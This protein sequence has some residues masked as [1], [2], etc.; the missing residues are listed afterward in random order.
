[1]R[2]SNAIM[3]IAAAMFIS[4]SIGAAPASAGNDKFLGVW[5][6]TVQPMGAPFTVPN[7]AANTAD[8]RIVNSDPTFGAGHGLW[9]KIG[10]RKYAVSLTHIIDAS[11][12][13]F[14]APPGQP[15]VRVTVEGVT[16]VKKDGQ[17]ASGTFVTTFSDL[18][19]APIGSFE[20]DVSFSRYKIA[21]D[22]LTLSEYFTAAR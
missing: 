4:F 2:I 13:P 10:N 3:A 12:S 22:L 6:V 16:K 19:G 7:I 20:G 18:T 1:M 5:E 14:P 11:L 9:E 17:T 15:F 21:P 8:G